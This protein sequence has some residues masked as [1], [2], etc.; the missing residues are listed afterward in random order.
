MT[1]QACVY[2]QVLI[3]SDQMLLKYPTTCKYEVIGLQTHGKGTAEKM[4]HANSHHKKSGVDLTITDQQAL[5]QRPLE[6]QM[7]QY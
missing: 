3:L 1:I 4:H 5:N 7:L 6:T 2:P